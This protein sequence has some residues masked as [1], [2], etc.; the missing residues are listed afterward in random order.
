V[1]KDEKLF[2][3]EEFKIP[4]Q[5]LAVPPSLNESLVSVMDKL[6]K[7]LLCM[8]LPSCHP[9]VR[10]RPIRRISKTSDKLYIRE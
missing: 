10:V 9:V 1:D 6:F 4:I 3:I 5:L 2:S 8:I 7:T